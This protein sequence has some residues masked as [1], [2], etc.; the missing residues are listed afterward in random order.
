MKK[1]YKMRYTYQKNHGPSWY[2][3]GKNLVDE[4]KYQVEVSKRKS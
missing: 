1:K 4:K 3:P 2:N